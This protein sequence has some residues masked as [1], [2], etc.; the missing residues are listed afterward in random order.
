MINALTIDVE[1]YF[2]VSN[3]ESLIG[4]KNWDKYES[5]VE[6]NTK[7]I[8]HILSE[9]N[10]KAT[11]FIL[12]WVAEKHPQLILEIYKDGHEIASH[13]YAHRLVYK[14]TLKEFRGD[15]R[16]SKKIIEDAI[17]ERIIGY[18]APSF[19]ITKDS[20][21]AL[22]ILMEEGFLYDSS[23]FPVIH[24]RYGIT[25]SKRFPYKLFSKDGR[26]FYEIP[27]STLAVL[28]KNIPVAGGGYLRLFPYI[29]TKW[30]LDRINKKE[31]QPVIIYLHP[32]EIDRYQP[33]LKASL[34]SKF[35]HYTNL[36]KMENNL[37]Q[38]LKDFKFG[39]IRDLLDKFADR[40]N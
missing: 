8:L 35:R 38:L 26:H 13:G 23:I 22:D 3:F 40:F 31:K 19:S 28:K 32:W 9:N 36:D 11:F 25:N 4:F 12:G 5:R 20:L 21:W 7:K 10:V 29:F 30:A 33:R 37:I 39:R 2:Q 17:G 6:R 34:M 27:L 18:R 1:D 24:H 14:Q 15:L 16:I